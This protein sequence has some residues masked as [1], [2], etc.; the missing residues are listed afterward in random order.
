M[1]IYGINE[2]GGYCVFEQAKEMV[3][4]SEGLDEDGFLKP[5]PIERTLKALKYF[6]RLIE[7]NNV[8]TV[9]ALST[10]AVR[11]AEN[12]RYFLE[13]VKSKLGLNFRVLTGEQEAYYDYLG[14][15][16]TLAFDD[17]VLVDIGGGSTEI[18]L[19][20]NREIVNSVSLPFG[21]VILTE[22]FK[23]IKNKKKQIESAEQFLSEEFA[24]LPWLQEGSGLPVIGLGGII[25]SLGKVH[26]NLNQ[27]PI[28]SLHNYNL[29]SE[30]VL[31]I[32]AMIQN[33]P[34]EEIEKISGINKRR[35]DLMT[36]GMM[37]LKVIMGMISSPKLKIS[38]YG[39]REGCF[40]EYLN[41][42]RG[43]PVVVESVLNHSVENMM[44]RFSVNQTHAAQVHFLSESLFKSLSELHEFDESE[45]KLLKV[46]ANLHDIGIHIDYY[47][48]HLHGMYLITNS[49]IDGLS[50]LEQLAV[51]FL[52][53]NHRD[54]NVK[55]RFKSYE[56]FLQRD[57]LNHL[58]KLAVI[59]QLAEQLDRT[60]SSY[61][62][63]LHVD[64]R[65][66]T[67]YLK[68]EAREF[69][70]LDIESAMRFANRFKKYYNRDL[71][72]YV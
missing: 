7:V 67:V 2:A 44:R 69:P 17:A 68:L 19:V 58:Y 13:S 41:Q 25:R 29:T 32:M 51:A 11:M 30:A 72:I 27:Y 55:D 64:I 65:D 62:Q 63:N 66:A 22:H 59:L 28:E 61:I 47:D 20:K 18:V 43:L 16:N 36:L 9:F 1:N 71:Q 35:A 45:L 23:S 24:K 46:A 48:H 53:G 31:D 12:Q 40:L 33:V 26:R 38:A 57:Y 56:P 34:Q 6:N 70:D 14:V 21:S 60:E 10:A 39:L 42:R 4:L 37:P 3:R 8:E 52:V 49:K 54:A 50:N 15:V 5:E